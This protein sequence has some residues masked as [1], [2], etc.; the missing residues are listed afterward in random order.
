MKRITMLI[1][2][3]LFNLSCSSDD[4]DGLSV[5]KQ[6]LLGK[7]YLKGGIV[8]NGVFEDYNHDCVTSR[9]FQEF[10]SNN[11]VTFN[12]YNIDCEL[13][14]I[15]E[16][17]WSLNGR[18]ITVSNTQFDPMIYEYNFIVEKLTSD[19]LILKQDGINEDTGQPEVYRLYLTKN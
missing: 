11:I 4:N 10:F 5:T 16:S 18:K 8:N 1:I 17:N 14:E 19:E 13:D 6:N 9:D 12:G 15:E 7:W 3:V 2:L